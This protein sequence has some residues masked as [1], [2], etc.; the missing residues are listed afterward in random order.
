MTASRSKVLRALE[1]EMLRELD[2]PRHDGWVVV[3]R[4]SLNDQR[5]MS[6]TFGARQRDVHDALLKFMS[7]S[8]RADIKF[9]RGYPIDGT[10]EAQLRWLRR[11]GHTVKKAMVQ[12]LE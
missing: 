8:C 2:P 3:I 12:V 6:W 10:R 7:Q 4:L 11:R 1:R 9:A 5:P